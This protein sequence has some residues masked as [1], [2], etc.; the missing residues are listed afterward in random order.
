MFIMGDTT[1]EKKTIEVPME[2]ELLDITIE[3]IESSGYIGVPFSE[4]SS[5]GLVGNE[6][7]EM[8]NTIRIPGGEGIYRVTFPKGAA[9]ALSKFKDD[10]AFFGAIR[11]GSRIEGQARLTQLAF[12]PEQVFMAIA[13]MDIS[14]KLN[15][16]LETQKI[17]LEFLYAQEESKIYGNYCMLNEAI[18]NYKYNWDQDHYINQN[19]GL[20]RN[21]KNEMY[22][23]IDLSRRQI[24]SILATPDEL[25]FLKT[26]GKKVKELVRLIRNYH[27]AEYL[28]S[29][30]TFFETLLIKNFR[31]ENLD[32][33]RS[34]LLSHA[35]EYQSLHQE[36]SNWA[37]HYI[38][39]S[40]NYKAAP[41]LFIADKMCEKPLERLHIGVNRAYG[42]E[43]ELYRPVDEQV[44]PLFQYK[45]TDTLVFAEGV[46][47][48][49]TLNNCEVN[50]YIDGEKVY[51]EV[52]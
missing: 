7:L 3:K 16:I 49:N 15:E 31:K 48:I 30:T 40:I 33:I 50:M 29:Y 51:I 18:K 17:M 13:L 25:H 37:E 38:T 47:R 35:Q 1:L 21:I 12:N 27:N 10:N 5:Y 42:N 4:I 46:K 22:K 43:S 41:I 2:V 8:I 34:T 11:A 26:A 36:S 20:V 14:S 45:E 9:G 19:M 32:N 24:E 23:S 52:H 6:L 44:V 28:L 39:S